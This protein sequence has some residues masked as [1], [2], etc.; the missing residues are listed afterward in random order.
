MEKEGQGRRRKEKKW[1]GKRRKEKE[2]EGSKEHKKIL[3]NTI[4]GI[5]NKRNNEKWKL[6]RFSDFKETGLK[7][8]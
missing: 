5:K 8:L 2:G 7:N 1:E 6:D 4:N 3:K